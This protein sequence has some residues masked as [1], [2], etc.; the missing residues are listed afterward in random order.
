MTTA[1]KRIMVIH[2]PNL[3]L[4]GKREPDIYGHTTLEAIDA[5]IAEKAKQLNLSVTFF[6]SNH[7]G[8]IVD[9]IQ[10]TMD[11]ENGLIINPA[12]YTH[13]SVA[14]RDALQMLTIPII[15]VHLSNIYKREDF[16]HR[17]LTAAAATAQVAGF[18]ARGYLLALEGLMHLL[19]TSS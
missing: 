2:G 15:E 8:A 14:I 10:A 5:E 12:A 4:L 17:S 3:N 6:Q 18:G 11:H 9:I 7:E 13:T 19:A 1:Q 16:R